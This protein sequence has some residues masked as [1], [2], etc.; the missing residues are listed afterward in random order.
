MTRVS[1][2][3]FNNNKRDPV[4]ALDVDTE[5]HKYKDKTDR[6]GCMFCGVKVQFTRGKEHNDPHFKNWPLIR[7]KSSCDIPN[8]ERQKE[9]Y[10]N[11]GEIELLVSTILPRAKRLEKTKKAINVNRSNKAKIYG[12][13]RSKKFIYNIVNLL[14]KQNL[15]QLKPE[16]EDLEL[17]IEDGSRIKLKELLGTQDEIIKRINESEEKRVTCILRGNTRKAQMVKNN[18]KIPL[19][20]GNN[21]SYKNTQNFSLF[22]RW[23]YVDKNKEF[24]ESIENSLI[25]CYGEALTN[26]FG[27][28]ME[29]FSVR[30]QVVVLKKYKNIL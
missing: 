2:A 27:T 13:R 9:N 26:E 23:D 18:I 22:I 12:G 24:I 20:I 15:Y 17:L 21:P 25:L 6:F 14:C 19:T 28:E 10:D 1:H 11:D 29:I 30:H 7:H 16:Y 3:Y 4:C 8:I 5:Y